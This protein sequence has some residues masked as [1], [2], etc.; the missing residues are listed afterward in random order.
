MERFLLN[1]LRK[2]SIKRSDDFDEDCLAP[3]WQWNYQPRKDYFSLTERPGWL[4]LKAYRPLETNNLLKAGNTLTQR[5]FRKQNNDVTIKMDISNMQD[6]QKNGL[7][8]FSSQ[9]SAIGVVKEG[10]SLLS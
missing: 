6:G 1:I 8:H 4:R 7:C 9:H 2:L 10:D 3:Q 5:T